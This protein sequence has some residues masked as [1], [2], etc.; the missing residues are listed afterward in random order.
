MFGTLRWR[1]TLWYGAVAV[2]LLV[3]FAFIPLVFYATGT[4]GPRAVQTS[5][6]RLTAENAERVLQKSGSPAEVVRT[7]RA[8]NLW[9]IVRG[10]GGKVLASTP[11]AGEPPDIGL[12][13]DSYPAVRQDEGYFATSLKSEG[14]SGKTIE[15]YTGVPLREDPFVRR[16]VISQLIGLL[17]ALG[18]M[19]GLGPTLAAAALKPLRR[20]S[21]VAGELREG[22]LESRVD[23]PDLKSRRDEVGQ[24]AASFDTMAESLEKLFAAERESKEG[25]RRFLADASHELRTPLTSILGYLDVLEERG[26]TDPNIRERAYAAMKEEGGRMA[27]LVE[28]L[29]TLARLESR[30]K[31][32]LAPTDLVELARG[33]VASYPGRRIKVSG[34]GPVVVV[35]EPESLRRVISNL[36]SNA[37]KHTPPN[38]EIEVS[39]KHLEREA[40]LRVS[41]EGEGI[42]GED[43]PHV[44]ERF[45]Q[46]ETSRFGEGTGLGLTI[47]RETVENL[48]GHVEVESAPGKGAT[49][50]VRLPLPD[51]P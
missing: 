7:I 45:Y 50:T 42:S 34:A 35:A 2:V 16:L 44:F 21:E 1:L 39:V 29:L 9:V 4:S 37:V 32:H 13:P 36:L 40:V 11:G 15:V 19:V 22:R 28:D 49:F 43:L 17:V 30:Q 10:A 23:L 31:A 51:V 12:P 3:L 20:V 27:R 25:M 24:L 46:A 26:D 47:V 14:A 33:A 18:L 38:G 8:P 5:E 6:V 41:D 48:G